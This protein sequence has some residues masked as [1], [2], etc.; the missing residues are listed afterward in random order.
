MLRQVKGKK[1]PTSNIRIN[2][3]RVECLPFPNDLFS[4]ILVVDAF[5]HFGDQPGALRE[6]VRLLKPGGRLV[7][8]EPDIRRTRVKFIAI[9]ETLALMGSHFRTGNHICQMLT[10]LGLHTQFEDDGQSTF[11][12][13]ATKE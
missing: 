6:L 3:A 4:R 5:H 7:I 10:S 11:W 2:M 13:I 1:L 8:E 9:G 12:V